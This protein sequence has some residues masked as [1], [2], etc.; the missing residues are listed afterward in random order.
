MSMT[1]PEALAL[2]DHASPLPHLTD[3]HL[4]ILRHMLGIDKPEERDPKPYR[5]YYCANKGNAC[6][7]QMER[8]GAVRLYR[9]CEDYDWYTTTEAGREAAIASHRKIRLPKSKRVYSKYLDIADV[10]E[11]LTFREFLTNPAYADARAAA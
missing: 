10:H 11:G 3:E 7:L 9:Q 1:L 4:R 2:A 8:Q 6:L 5:D